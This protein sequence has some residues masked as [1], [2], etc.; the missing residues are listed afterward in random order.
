MGEKTTTI[1]CTTFYGHACSASNTHIS[2]AS[3]LGPPD[4]SHTS[5]EHTIDEEG[6]LDLY[7]HQ[8][9]PEVPAAITGIEDLHPLAKQ[10]LQEFPD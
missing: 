10:L 2:P 9:D 3:R 7:I 8:P 1:Y 4:D 5:E 6:L